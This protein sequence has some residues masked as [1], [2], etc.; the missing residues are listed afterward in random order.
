[1]AMSRFKHQEL[2]WAEAHPGHVRP[3][4]EDRVILRV[5]DRETGSIREFEGGFDALMLSND[6]AGDQLGDI[7]EALGP[8]VLRRWEED[9]DEVDLVAEVK[10]L[11]ARRSPASTCAAA[12]RSA[13]PVTA[14]WS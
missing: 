14:T 6:A 2:P 10:A 12:I 8:E 13:W 1:M 4:D 9:G 7:A 3:Q 11:H 5:T